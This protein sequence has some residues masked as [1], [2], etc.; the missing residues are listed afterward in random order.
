MTKEE[1]QQK[2]EALGVK[3]GDKFEELWNDLEAKIDA[4]KAKLDTET[5]RKVR[6]FWICVA[7][8]L[9]IVIGA[10]LHAAYVWLF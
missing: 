7:G 2:L 1:L 5:R 8:G 3:V 10:A 9:G 4:E 6:A